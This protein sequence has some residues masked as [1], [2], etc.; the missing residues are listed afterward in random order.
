MKIR[1]R[2]SQ[3]VQCGP[4][5]IMKLAVAFRSFADAP[6]TVRSYPHSACS[7]VARTS[8]QTAIYFLNSINQLFL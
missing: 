6:N 4:T 5:D 1:L 7:H 3:V 8:E 2:E